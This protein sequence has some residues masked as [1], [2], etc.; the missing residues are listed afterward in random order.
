MHVAEFEK[1]F[2]LLDEEARKADPEVLEQHRAL[3]A[4]LGGGR[5]PNDLRPTVLVPA[6]RRLPERVSR[7]SDEDGTVWVSWRW[8][9]VGVEE[10][11][12]ARAR[13]HNFC[14][15][16]PHPADSSLTDGAVVPHRG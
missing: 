9:G 14:R 10:W 12:G 3:T 8:Q 5:P 16:R 7:T 13:S 6:R 1:H 15:R 2:A 4:A 11:G